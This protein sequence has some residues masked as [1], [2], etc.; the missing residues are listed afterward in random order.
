MK[1]QSQDPR[2]QQ[3]TVLLAD[4]F[5]AKAHLL[6]TYLTQVNPNVC[7]FSPDGTSFYIYDQAEFAQSLP[8]YFKHNNY[9]SFVRQLNLYGFNSSRLKDNNEVIE[10]KHENFHRERKDLVNS[11]KRTK[12]KASKETKPST[13]P[14]HV[15]VGSR[16]FSPNTPSYSDEASS[17]VAESDAVAS[18]TRA[19]DRK[20]SVM[21][22]EWMAAEFAALKRQNE[23][24]E[25]KLDT[26][27]KI[28]FR[29]SSGI[30][31]E[32]QVHPG[33]KRRRTSPVASGKYYTR[34]E[35]KVPDHLDMEPYPYYPAKMPPQ[36]PDAGDDNEVGDSLSTFIDIMLNEEES[37]TFEHDDRVVSENDDNGSLRASASS[38]HLYADYEDELMEEALNA[39]LPDSTLN[40]DGDLF[41]LEGRS[42]LR[43]CSGQRI[44]IANAATEKADGPEPIQVI[45][46]SNVPTYELG[47]IE[48]ANVTVAMHVVSAQ[49]ELVEDDVR[50]IDRAHF[51]LWDKRHKKVMCLL[52]AI[53]FAV[54]SFV[55]IFPP[56]YVKSEKH[57]S[58][59]IEQITTSD[60]SDPDRPRPY[61]KSGYEDEGED[62]FS[63][64]NLEVMPS[65]NS[66][67]I[68]KTLRQYEPQVD[69]EGDG[70]DTSVSRSPQPA[71]NYVQ[72]E[73]YMPPDEDFVA[74]TVGQ[75]SYKCF[76]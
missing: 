36:G 46:T 55:I 2:L 59:E 62:I 51:T 9:G 47:D 26:L 45:S 76:L 68:A 23:L 15:H 38:N 19:F 24:L 61:R 30:F 50:N 58:S 53:A 10:W 49:A 17:I 34:E 4:T 21:D 64:T 41:G 8:Q 57:E 44:T 69:Q 71:Q 28:T 16:P 32:Q 20:V 66:T 11:I 18:P 22:Y 70:V 72:Y 48:E 65:E 43:N 75:A 25:H 35:E 3:P 42:S 73:D 54:V 12:Y 67:S 27:L 33:E 31:L 74:I 14:L 29:I 13:K 6:V 1:I 63:G 40:T 7:S 56:V 37:K 5:P 52:C 39:N 60:S